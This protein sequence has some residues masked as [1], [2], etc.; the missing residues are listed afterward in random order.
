MSDIQWKKNRELHEKKIKVT[1]KNANLK[2]RKLK[3]KGIN[4]VISSYVRAGTKTGNRRMS[5]YLFPKLRLSDKLRNL[6]VKFATE[7]IDTIRAR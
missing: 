5:H 7:G 3:E 4:L 2:N 1:L 6:E